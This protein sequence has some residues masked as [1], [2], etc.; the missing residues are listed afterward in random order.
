MVTEA[1]GIMHRKNA[2]PVP[3]ARGKI[4]VPQ[5]GTS[6]KTAADRCRVASVRDLADTRQLPV[7]EG[8]PTARDARGFVSFSFYGFLGFL[9]SVYF[10]YLLHLKFMLARTQ[11]LYAAI[12]YGVAHRKGPCNPLRSDGFVAEPRQLCSARSRRY[13]VRC[14][15]LV[16]QSRVVSELST[17][18]GF[19]LSH[20]SNSGT[21]IWVLPWLGA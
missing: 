20:A 7:G 12:A 9:R 1:V 13:F 15:R 10:M 11:S 18:A 2:I 5:G 21:G 3:L 6:V 4:S 16:S 19:I 17:I 8:F 14:I